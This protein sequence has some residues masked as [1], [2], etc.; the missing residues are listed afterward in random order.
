MVRTAVVGLAMALAVAPAATAMPLAAKERMDQ[1]ARRVG[2]SSICGRMGYVVADGYMTSEQATA[3]ESAAVA[4]LVAL[5][6]DEAEARAEAAAAIARNTSIARSEFAAAMA[7]TRGVT[8]LRAQVTEAFGRWDADCLR[9]SQDSIFKP[10][11]TA[12]PEA[13]RIARRVAAED[14]ILEANGEA[15]WQGPKSQ[16]RGDLFFMVGLCRRFIGDAELEGYRVRLDDDGPRAQR[17]YEAQWAE[18]IDRAAAF[19]FDEAGCR[20]GLTSAAAAAK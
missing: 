20:R 6:A 9:L 15:S 19:N 18:G 11:I 4:E 17:L 14:A 16:A 1:I 7:K 13:E 5:G 2:Q 10:Y 12:M 8:S 3:M